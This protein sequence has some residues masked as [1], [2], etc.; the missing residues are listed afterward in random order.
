MGG[1]WEGDVNDCWKYCF[2]RE[3]QVV[4]RLVE[5]VKENNIDGVDI[6]YE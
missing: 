6:D 2:G 4:D 1:S 5:I 3:T